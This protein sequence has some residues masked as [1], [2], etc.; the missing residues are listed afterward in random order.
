MTRSLRAAQLWPLLVFAAQNRQTLTYKTVSILTGL[1]TPGIGQALFPIQYY[2]EAKGLPKLTALVVKEKS[3][4][5]GA[6]L[7]LKSSELPRVLQE[8]FSCNWLK[9]R[10]P[11]EQQLEVFNRPRKRR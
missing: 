6:G 2:C 9:H 8:V 10:A 7:P 3:G 5:P 1:K 11:D 4:M